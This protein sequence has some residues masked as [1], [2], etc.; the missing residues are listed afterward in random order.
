M[1]IDIS[2]GTHQWHN[3]DSIWHDLEPTTMAYLKVDKLSKAFGVKRVLNTV[4]FGVR[5]GE[6]MAVF[7][8]NGSGKST[9]FQILFGK[10]KADI[11][12]GHIDGQS[13][14]ENQLQIAFLP[15]YAFL[16]TRMRV[17]KLIEKSVSSEEGQDKLFYAP[18][19]S[20]IENQRVGQLSTGERRY[21]ATLLLGQLPH[22]FILLDE[23]FSMLEPIQMEYIKHYLLELKATKGIILTDHY[24]DDVL[25]VA[26]R[27]L[28]LQGGE[29][30]VVKDKTDLVAKGYLPKRLLSS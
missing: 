22:S 24:F 21:L 11:L 29:L 8:R 3:C 27:Y 20:K 7:G 28:L 5:T 13:I 19:I 17:R 18:K 16:P 4:S 25:A 15:Q 6:I 2:N 14:V 23:P 12:Q 30:Q 26:D 1:G 10:V 9:I